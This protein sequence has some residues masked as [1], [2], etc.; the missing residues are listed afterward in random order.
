MATAEYVWETHDNFQKQTLRNRCYIATDQGKQMLN[1]PIKHVGG[2]QG[3]QAYK[4]V[5]LDFSTSWQKQ[6][7]KT[8]QTAYR[9]S[10]FFEY[11]EDDIA[12]F[13]EQRFTHLMEMNFAS[14]GIIADCLGIDI[15]KHTT[16]S[17]QKELPTN[18]DYRSL[19]NA[20]K[21]VVIAQEPYTQV[22]GDR[23][24]FLNNLS[25]LDVLFNKGPEALSYLKQLTNTE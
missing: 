19:V 5:Q 7:W 8:L 17:Y 6:H 13:F 10:P 20:K 25:T 2:T 23:H 4:D 12:P 18:I 1:V 11:Y 3:R 21:P 9:T 15:T 14:I 22:F 16:E 24:G